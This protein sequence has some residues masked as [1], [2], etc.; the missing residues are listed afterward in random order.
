MKMKKLIPSF[1]MTFMLSV[2]LIGCSSNEKVDSEASGTQ[3]VGEL[4]DYEIIGIE[5]GSGIHGLTEKSIDEYELDGWKLVEGSSSA[6]LATLDKAYKKK[7][8]I[9]VTAWEPHWMFS[10]YDLKLLKDDKVIFGEPEKI[11]TLVRN[12]FKEDQPNAYKFFKQF[13]WKSEDLALVMQMIED[14][15][16]PE[17]AAGKWIK[18]HPDTVNKWIEGVE[19]VNGEKITLV[20]N[21]WTDIIAS[22]N[23]VAKALKDKG[24]DVNLMQVDAA[25]IFAGLASGSA[26]AFVG[27]WLPTAH[28]S[29]YEKYKDQIETVGVN[30]EGTVM[31]LAVPTYMEDINSL[32]DLGKKMEELEKK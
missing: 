24:Y 29:Y 19:K 8:P 10:K 16:E 11:Y 27:A 18:E 22:T 32:E 9:V 2:A 12:G 26:D 30:L 3:P 17:A 13:A 25:P 5:A 23:V 14:G 4:F 21:S 20:Y 6:M 15:L 1:A 7:E 28:S 31:G